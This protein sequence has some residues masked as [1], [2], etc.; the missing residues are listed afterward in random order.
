LDTT[1][2]MLQA[3]LEGRSYKALAAE[4]GVSP[5]AGE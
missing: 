3:V 5:S 4:C 1:V 2:R